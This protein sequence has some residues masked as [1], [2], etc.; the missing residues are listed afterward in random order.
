MIGSDLLVVPI[1]KLIGAIP[2]HPGCRNRGFVCSGTG[3]L[4]VILLVLLL[5]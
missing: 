4:L 1:L 5:L 2:G 3:L